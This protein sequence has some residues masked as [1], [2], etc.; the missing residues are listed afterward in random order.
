MIVYLTP[1]STSIR[2]MS[3]NPRSEKKI[4]TLAEKLLSGALTT[5]SEHKIVQSRCLSRVYRFSLPFKATAWIHLL[6]YIFRLFRN[7]Y[8]TD[9]RAQ[10]VMNNQKCLTLFSWRSSSSIQHPHLTLTQCAWSSAGCRRRFRRSC[11]RPID[12]LNSADKWR[13]RSISID[14]INEFKYGTKTKYILWF[15]NKN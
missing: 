15:T 14:W 12:S 6:Y 5:S 13:K 8:S 9:I 7:D 11:H 2:L 4:D 10:R 3:L 1:A